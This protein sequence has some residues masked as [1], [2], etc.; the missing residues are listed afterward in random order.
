MFFYI[1][2]LISR[3]CI[4]LR[5]SCSI[6]IYLALQT[7]FLGYITNCKGGKSL[8]FFLKISRICLLKRFRVIALP[9]YEEAVIPSFGVSELDIYIFNKLPKQRLF[10]SITFLKE[11]L[12]KSLFFLQNFTQIIFCDPLFCDWQ[13][14]FDHLLFSF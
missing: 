4:R 6:S 5:N 2:Y 12:F 10:L 13:V 3:E 14:L 8:K 1:S 9:K 7:A 11:D